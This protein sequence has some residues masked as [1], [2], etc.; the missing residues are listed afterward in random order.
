MRG[1]SQRSL[2]VLFAVLLALLAPLRAQDKAARINLADG[3]DFPVG[4]P[5]ATGYYIARGVR[6]TAPV[7]FGEDW[8]GR[9]GG[10]TDLGD[11]VYACGD[12]VVTWAYDVH[13]GWGNVVL[14]RHAYRD[15]DDGKVKFC[16]S[17][18]GHMN[19][20]MVK[21]GQLVK[22]GQQIGTI[23]TNHGMYPAH[24]HFEIRNN[25]YIG[26]QRESVQRDFNNW[27]VPSD[28]IKKY[29][30]LNRDWG[31]VLAPIGTY[32]D[33]QGFKGL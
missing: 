11:P 17:L 4:K 19:E 21:V 23:G 16:D 30:R 10:D 25:V 8:N 18:Y 22:R 20:I 31:K 12:G 27:A 5:D 24:L 3:F 26:M 28:F 13:V 14:I 9:G 6:L 15:P 33:Y 1:A 29:R 2:F 32:T 7:H